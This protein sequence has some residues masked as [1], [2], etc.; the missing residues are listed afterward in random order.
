MRPGEPAW[1]DAKLPAQTARHNARRPTRNA[2]KML[3]ADVEAQH[4]EALKQYEA[5]LRRYAAELR[6]YQL[7]MRWAGCMQP[8]R[9]PYRHLCLRL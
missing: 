9:H 1:R 4:A 7:D 3:D 5:D 8:I 2:A 6:Q